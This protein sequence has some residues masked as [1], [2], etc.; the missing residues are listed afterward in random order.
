MPACSPR[1]GR[2]TGPRRR[3]SPGRPRAR[4]APADP[5]SDGRGGA[6]LAAA[7]GPAHAALLSRAACPARVEQ[8]ACGSPSRGRRSAPSWVWPALAAAQ[9]PGA[10]HGGDPARPTLLPPPAPTAAWRERDGAARRSRS[11]PGLSGHGPGAIRAS[12]TSSAQADARSGSRAGLPT[13]QSSG[14]AR[15]AAGRWIESLRAIPWVFAWTQIRLMLPAWL[16]TDAALHEALAADEDVLLGEMIE[17]W[18][19]FRM[20]IDMLEMVLAKTDVELVRWYRQR[21]TDASMTGLG[22]AL[23]DRVETLTADLLELRGRTRLLEREPALRESLDVRNTYLDPLH[24]LQAELLARSRE[25]GEPPESVERALQVTM[26]GIARW[27][28]N[29]G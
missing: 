22:E 25:A 13:G 21:L 9:D 19:F 27:S 24:L 12:S 16:G 11:W 28:T 14:P 7:G 23:C 1:P 20:Q 26:A 2:S 6:V 15:R 4:R 8:A 3:W 5:V 29:T 18:P 10:V 17:H